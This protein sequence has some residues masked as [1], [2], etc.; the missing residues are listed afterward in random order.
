MMDQQA[1]WSGMGLA[2]PKIAIALWCSLLSLTLLDRRSRTFSWQIVLSGLAI[3]ASWHATS[4]KSVPQGWQTAWVVGGI[5]SAAAL[6]DSLRC[7]LASSAPSSSSP[8]AASTSRGSEL[9]G[10]ERS[11]RVLVAIGLVGLAVSAAATSTALFQWIEA[12]NFVKMLA[13]GYVLI[14][15][16][17]LGIVLAI[18]IELTF[19]AVGV[20]LLELGWKWIARIVTGLWLLQLLLHIEMVIHHRPPPSSESTSAPVEAIAPIVFAFGMTVVGYVVW[21]IGQRMVLLASR[22]EKK[23]TGQTSLAMAG[24]LACIC[25]GLA[26]CLPPTWPWQNLT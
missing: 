23:C 10:G 7:W 18:S 4:I 20:G 17:L 11:R 21:A 1:L 19:G 13:I 8:S 25:F 24:W 5:L 15:S 12:T 2:S 3:W 9:R 16:A 22:A 26:C 14:T 6:F